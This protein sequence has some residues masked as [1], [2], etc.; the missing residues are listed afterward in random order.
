[1]EVLNGVL[2]GSISGPRHRE[3]DVF[4]HILWTTRAIDHVLITP[5]DHMCTT[6]VPYKGYIATYMV[7]CGHMWSYADPSD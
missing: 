2:N 1:M 6:Y 7:I 4:E 5:D 3:M